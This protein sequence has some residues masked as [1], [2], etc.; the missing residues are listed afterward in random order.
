M[1]LINEQ[2]WKAVVLFAFLGVAC[3]VAG[4]RTKDYWHNFDD[5]VAGAL[6]G[7]KN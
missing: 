3:Y 1:R 7:K 5:I 2:M 6:I 4:T